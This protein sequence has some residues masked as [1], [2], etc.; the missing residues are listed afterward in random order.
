[1]S[2][3][4]RSSKAYT[5]P[6]NHGITYLPEDNPLPADR[7][8][9]AQEVVATLQRPVHIFRPMKV[10][11]L[12]G[13]P[14]CG[15]DT[16]ANLVSDKDVSLASFKKPMFSIAIAAA[17]VSEAEWFQRYDDRELKELPWD[18]L[19]G[20]SQRD[21]MI[22]ISEEWIKPVFGK[23][24]FGKLAASQCDNYVTLF[25]DGGFADEVLEICDLFGKRNVTLIHVY[26]DG[27]SFEKDRRSY[28]QIAGLNTVPLHLTEGDIETGLK[29]LKDII[30]K[31]TK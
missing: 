15:K 8:V 2:F 11:I 7:P 21:F 22:K 14:G 9:T 5:G 19:N 24:H 29:D 16:L 23:T 6:S 26:R 28:V 20:L 4:N 3:N 12:N 25:T 17:G 31:E 18:K 10:L 1:M 30:E 27:T 13:P